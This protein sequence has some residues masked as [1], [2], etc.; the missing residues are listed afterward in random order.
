MV[1]TVICKLDPAPEDPSIQI[2]Y[3]G[4]VAVDKRFRKRGIG[5][6][7]AKLG[8]SRMIS[9]GCESIILETEVYKKTQ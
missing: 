1:G 4:M 3:I 8:I 9:I 7:L 5:K 6:K 2:G